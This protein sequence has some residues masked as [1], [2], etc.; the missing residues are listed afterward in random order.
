MFDEFSLFESTSFDDIMND[1]YATESYNLFDDSY[2]YAFEELY[3]DEDI[4]IDESDA[5]SD[6]EKKKSGVWETIKKILAKFREFVANFLQGIKNFLFGAKDEKGAVVKFGVAGYIGGLWKA[7]KADAVEKLK[8]DA[9]KN[10][11]SKFLAIGASDFSYAF[12][13]SNSEKM[14]KHEKKLEK[15]TDKYVNYWYDL[16]KKAKEAGDINI[17]KFLNEVAKSASRQTS[18]KYD[19][20]YMA[21]AKKVLNEVVDV[22]G[23]ATKTA[24]Q[25]SKGVKDDK[26]VSKF[27]AFIGTLSRF[28]KYLGSMIK[29]MVMARTTSNLSR[30]RYVIYQKLLN[31]SDE[32]SSFIGRI[33]EESYNEG[34]NDALEAI[35]FGKFKK[36]YSTNN[37]VFSR[38]IKNL[39]KELERDDIS[40]KDKKEIKAF[41]DK[42]ESKTTDIDKAI[43][44]NNHIEAGGMLLLLMSVFISLTILPVIIFGTTIIC[45]TAIV[46]VLA[47]LLTY[48]KDEKTRK[49]IIQIL[50]KYSE[51]DGLS[52]EERKKIKALENKFK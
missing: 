44:Y 17:S 7:A 8:S 22:S 11:E 2:G 49:R 12:E 23:M 50:E 36:E 25:T 10:N 16:I 26:D 14:K 43:K 27:K 32:K 29:L 4:D 5:T 3:K 51:R 18:N 1:S 21:E 52:P 34:Y 9:A 31:E 28:F 48:K 42:Y 46:A 39:K 35:N 6:S 47:A 20:P 33:A 15:M 41:I 24:E 40:P 38:T 13:A 37:G 45:I 30:D 19:T